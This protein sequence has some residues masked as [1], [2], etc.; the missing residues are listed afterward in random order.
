MK[1]SHRSSPDIEVVLMVVKPDAHLK[2]VALTDPAEH[3]L[4]DDRH[5]GLVLVVVGRESHVAAARLTPLRRRQPVLSSSE[6]NSTSASGQAKS[7]PSGAR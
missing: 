2:R 7:A 4:H 6:M 3:V 1:E 5:I